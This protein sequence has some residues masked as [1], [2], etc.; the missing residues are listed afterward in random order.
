MN[1][2]SVKTIRTRLNLQCVSKAKDIKSVM[3]STNKSEL[4]V[5]LQLLKNETANFNNYYRYSIGVL[6]MEILNLILNGYGVESTRDINDFYLEYV[7]MGDT[8]INTICHYRGRFT[9]QSWG[10]I[11][12]RGNFN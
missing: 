3:Q 7:N 11:V 12:E 6:K 4:I 1:Y 5:R 2:P 10:D 8:Y 9:V